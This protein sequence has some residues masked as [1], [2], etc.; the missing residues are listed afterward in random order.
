M[1]SRIRERLCFRRK[2]EKRC[3]IWNDS[4]VAQSLLLRTN[5]LKSVKYGRPEHDH[6]M[7][8]PIIRWIE[9]IAFESFEL[10]HQ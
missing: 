8:G 9:V 10:N 7:I 6:N 5:H 4:K 1:R 3:F 2:L